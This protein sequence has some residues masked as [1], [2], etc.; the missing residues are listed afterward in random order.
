MIWS[1]LARIVAISLDGVYVLAQSNSVL[2]RLVLI[3]VKASG[4][5]MDLVG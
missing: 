5:C 1:G 4:E 3:S 2:L